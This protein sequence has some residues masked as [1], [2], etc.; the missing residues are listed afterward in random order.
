[1]Q[2]S[3][4]LLSG[5]AV[6]PQLRR[7][8]IG[9]YGFLI[10]ANVAVW[11]WAFLIFRHQPLMLG[12]AM[13]AYGFGLRHAVDADHIASID[14]VTRKLVQLGKWPL[15]T[16]FWF[17][18]GHSAIVV[19][20]ALGTDLLSAFLQTHFTNF[21]DV[22]GLISTLV[23]AGFL[24]VLAL[25][26]I[27]V[28]RGIWRTYRQV[29]AG[30]AYV[31]EDFNV[32]LSGRGLLARLL[33]PLFQLVTQSWHMF[34]LGFLF[35]LGFDTATEVSLLGLSASQASQGVSLGAVMLFP[36][37]F[38]AGMSLIDTTDGVLMLG[39]YRWAFIHPMRKIYYNL[40]ITLVSIV[41][42]LFIGCIETLRLI[43]DYCDGKGKFWR[44]VSGLSDNFNDLGFMIIAL[45]IVAWGVSMI[46]YRYAGTAQRKPN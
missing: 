34:L 12:N 33:R 23:S 10:S 5:Q 43:G 40:I 6:E 45:F 16:G 35:G 21:R 8:V 1:M 26:N 4:F 38:A 39:A 27:C 42:A 29:R 31:E 44:I 22:G 20:A 30:G 11:V 37:L 14:N 2:R 32:L 3:T 15:T 17:A 19:I 13:L 7:R 25:T 9:L 46:M 18:L 41:V 24:F 28:L 36:A